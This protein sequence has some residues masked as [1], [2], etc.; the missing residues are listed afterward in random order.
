MLIA[1]FER[2]ASP[3]I[4]DR[5]HKGNLRPIVRLAHMHRGSS[6]KPRVPRH[7]IAQAEAAT[8]LARHDGAAAELVCRALQRHVTA[9]DFENALHLDQVRRELQLLQHDT[10]NDT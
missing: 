8:L 1:L 6:L 3:G 9:G 10:A 5:V 7:P 4:A 2:L